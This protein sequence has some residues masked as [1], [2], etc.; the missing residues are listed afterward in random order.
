MTLSRNRLLNTNVF[1]GVK[2]VLA[3]KKLYATMLAVLVLCAFIMIVPQNLH[4]TISSKNFTAY[5]GIGDSDLRIDIQQTDH[6]A[7]KAGEIAAALS[8]D[9]SVAKLSVLATKTFTAKLEDGSEARLKIELGDHSIF[10]V[11]YSEG[12]GPAADH[13]IALSDLN[14][15]ELDKKAGD[16]LVLTVEGKEKKFTVSGIYSDITNGGKT[17][18]AVFHDDAA[19][20]MWYVIS[21]KLNDPSLIDS[22]VKEYASKFEYAKV[23][24]LDEFIAQTFGSTIRSVGKASRAAIAVAL[25]IA[26]LI[27]LLFMRMLVSKDRVSI[28]VMKALGYTGSDIRM[29]YVSRSLFVLIIGIVL[30]TVLANT[31]GEMLARAVI[32]SL[33]A[34]AFQFTVNP[35]AAYLFSPLLMTGSVLLAAIIA[36]SG[37]AR[38]KISDN[39]KE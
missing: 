6:L 22:K 39:I 19:D 36:T 29:Q 18:K 5:M 4:S 26:V 27:T 1:L 3:R 13:E 33:G 37:A 2:D 28:A 10:P 34:S 12:R 35:L 14:A 32:S 11:H 20:T 24:D 7:E 17:A 15:G 16:S 23:S 30:G 9:R 8:S 21:A 25:M 31:I 38:I